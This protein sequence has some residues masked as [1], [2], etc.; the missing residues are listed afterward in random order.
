[1]SY[2]PGNVSITNG[3][4]PTAA[5]VENDRLA[6]CRPADRSAA[7]TREALANIV[8]ER[9]ISDARLLSAQDKVDRALLGHPSD[10]KRARE[11]L[12]TAQDEVDQYAAREAGMRVALENREVQERGAAAEL[13][14]LYHAAEDRAAKFRAFLAKDY[15]KHAAAIAAGIALEREA[16]HADVILRE[17]AKL[18]PGV[19]C[20]RPD[21]PRAPGGAAYG[22]SVSLPGH[23]TP[24]GGASASPYAQG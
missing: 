13:A 21:I 6:R 4:Q 18:W 16:L 8:T 9:A 14:R 12:A 2:T 23:V 10:L 22:Y 17:T 20:S 19:A 11:A 15:S 1:M 24:Q 3:H 5:E 7:A